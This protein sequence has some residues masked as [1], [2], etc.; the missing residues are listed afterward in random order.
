MPPCT[1][2]YP[3]TGQLNCT[4]GYAYELVCRQYYVWVSDNIMSEY[5]TVEELQHRSIHHKGCTIQS[6]K[7]GF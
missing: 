5:Q 2:I 4:T 3:S 6:Q 1:A 7:L